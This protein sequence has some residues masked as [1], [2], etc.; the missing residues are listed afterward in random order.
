MNPITTAAP[1]SDPPIHLV[2]YRIAEIALDWIGTPFYPGQ[3]RKGVGADCV[4]FAL[5]VYKEAGIIPLNVR[6]P[7][8][9]LGDGD[10]LST[11]LVLP[12]IESC[13]FF[14]REEI[15]RI[16]SL[17]TF[18]FGR[19]PHHVGVMV[20]GQE[21]VQ[22]IRGYG[23]RKFTLQ[24]STWSKRLRTVWFPKLPSDRSAQSA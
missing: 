13:G 15:P 16:G 6:L 24:D 4:Q 10:H 8:Y 18:E 19:V 9:N 3:A 2:Q 14:V 22:A 12:W 17:L 7:Q 23:V 5:R 1:A 21:F 20:S 11:G